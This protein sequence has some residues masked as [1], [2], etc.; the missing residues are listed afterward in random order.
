MMIERYCRTTHC[1]LGKTGLYLLLVALPSISIAAEWTVKPSLGVRQS[2]NDNIRL[3]T[4]PHPNVT[5]TTIKPTIDFG[6]ATERA[7]IDLF[8]EWKHNQ[9]AGDPNLENRTDRKYELKSGYKTERSQFS[10]DGSYVNDTTLAQ[11]DYSEDIGATLAQLDRQ[12]NRLTPTWSWMVDE[13]SNLR[14]DLQYQDVAYEKS[15]ISPFNDY[16]YDS[17]GLTYS[18][19]WTVRDQVY[20]MVNFSRYDSKKRAL[21]PDNEMV[22]TS[23]FLGSDSETLMYQ[24]GLNHQFSSTFKMG[25]G[26]GS[27][28]SKAKTQYQVCVP[29]LF[30]SCAYTTEI[31][32]ESPSKSPVYTVSADKDFELTKLGVKL[33]RTVSASGLGSEME[34][35]SLDFNIDRRLT[36]K[37][38]LKFKFMAN[39]RVAVNPDFSYQDRKLLR[40]EVNLGWGLDRNWKLYAMYRHTRQSYERTSAVASSN[41]ISLNIRYSW[42]R[43]SK[44]W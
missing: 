18:H 32:T 26:Y 38:L 14:V 27:R 6:W 3:T 44:S 31:Q 40:G 4:L 24:L 5:T 23:R 11:E 1:L 17:A 20:A 41:N 16:S 15:A 7:N 37:W 30:F 2:Y 19:Q 9:Y 43:I 35:D 21:I 34:V 10:L 33:S 22:A 13:R 42:D 36:E 28:D 8:G 12:T 29:F 39:Q 25:L